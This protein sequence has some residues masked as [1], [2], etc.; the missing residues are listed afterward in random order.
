MRPGVEDMTV[1][2]WIDAKTSMNANSFKTLVKVARVG[3]IVVPSTVVA[4]FSP[5]IT[6]GSISGSDTEMY[7][8]VRDTA[9]VDKFN[10]SVQEWTIKV[11]ME[12]KQSANALSHHRMSDQI[13]AEFP[14]LSD[15]IGVN[16]RFDKQFKLE[17]RSV[18]FTLAR[19]GVY[20]HQGAGKGY[21]GLSGS[22]WTDKYG[23]LKKT[24]E[25]SLG[26]MGTG[27]RSAEHWFNEP[28]RNHMDELADIV[29]EYSL[30]L[31]INMNSIFLPE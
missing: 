22:K 27:L 11:A 25:S 20:I 1:S 13:S 18:G 31:A 14:R 7:M 5:R 3:G 29:A 30:D 4:N 24:A 9:A 21:G 2:D 23:H 19:H 15:S 16:I 26:K 17:T 10:N 12:L 6:F 28:I 8:R